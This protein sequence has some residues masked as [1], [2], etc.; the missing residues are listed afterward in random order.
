[1]RFPQHADALALQFDLQGRLASAPDASTLAPREPGIAAGPRLPQVPG[2]EV[3][4]ELGRGGMGVVYKARQL[5]LNR[6][7]ALKLILA[8]QLASAEDVRR[9]Q[10]EA[11]AAAQLDHP[12]LVPVYE[13]GQQQGQH[14]FSMKLVE[15][16]SLAQHLPRLAHQPRVGVQLLA[17]VA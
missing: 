5:K 12:N 3:L 14:Y 16:V 15:G 11:E 6:I 4:G 8:G 2:Y 1:A 13:V 7:V 9:F 10:A 17:T